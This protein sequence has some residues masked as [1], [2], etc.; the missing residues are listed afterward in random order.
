[1]ID[2]D[3]LI[4]QLEAA[5]EGSREIDAAIATM[6]ASTERYAYSGENLGW[7]YSHYN[8]VSISPEYT[9]SLDAAMT[10][11]GDD[12]SIR[13]SAWDDGKLG[14]HAWLFAPSSPVMS[15][16]K[17][18]GEAHIGWPDCHS[19]KEAHRHFALALCIAA[20]R[21]RASQAKP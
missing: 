3:A 6:F 5:T 4:A 17:C 10:L 11:I 13:L 14:A 21:A 19:Y 20:L 18:W 15:D 9:S 12:W 1:M 2:L 7:Y 8:A 16:V